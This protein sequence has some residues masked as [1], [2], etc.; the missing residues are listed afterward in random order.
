MLAALWF[1]I[2]AYGTQE[3]TTWSMNPSD[4]LQRQ[5][6]SGAYM[7]LQY[8]TFKSHVIFLSNSW[9]QAAPYFARG[10]FQYMTYKEAEG[11]ILYCS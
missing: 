11:D 2:R 9:L 10:S 7:A 5:E 6:E 8:V 3:S 1:E 4:S